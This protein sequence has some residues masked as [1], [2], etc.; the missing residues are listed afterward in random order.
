MLRTCGKLHGGIGLAELYGD[1]KLF[2]WVGMLGLV[3]I[4]MPNSLHMPFKIKTR[5][6]K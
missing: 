3:G 6:I 5:C 2:K 1:V 4:S